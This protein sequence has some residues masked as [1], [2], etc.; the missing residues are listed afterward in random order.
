MPADLFRP[1]ARAFGF[2]NEEPVFKFIGGNMLEETNRMLQDSLTVHPFNINYDYPAGFSDIKADNIPKV[3]IKGEQDTGVFQAIGEDF[4][5]ASPL[6]SRLKGRFDLKAQITQRFNNVGIYALVSKDL[7]DG[8]MGEDL[9]GFF[10]QLRGEFYGRDCVS[11]GDTGVLL[12]DFINGVAGGKQV[13]DIAYG[14]PCAFEAGFAEAH[15]GVDGNPVFKLGSHFYSLLVNNI[16]HSFSYMS[17]LVI[18]GVS[19]FVLDIRISDLNY[20]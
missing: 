3:L 17:S 15:L 5:V 8:L 13:Q 7:H 18:S 10:T 14:D 11:L 19:P 4:S 6:Q 20:S 9:Y 1:D 2:N 16:Y 12:G